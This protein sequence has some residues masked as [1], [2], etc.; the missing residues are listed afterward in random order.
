M[1]QRAYIMAVI[2]SRRL[3]KTVIIQG[4]HSQEFTERALFRV[5]QT[6]AENF[7]LLKIM[8]AMSIDFLQ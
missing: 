3:C 7:V 4:Q 6:T 1:N 2:I 8:M 5:V